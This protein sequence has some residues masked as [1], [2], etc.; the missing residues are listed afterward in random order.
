MAAPY[1]IEFGD[2][3]TLLL[4]ADEKG[5]NGYSRLCEILEETLAQSIASIKD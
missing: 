2:I 5:L 4:C 3:K 1:G